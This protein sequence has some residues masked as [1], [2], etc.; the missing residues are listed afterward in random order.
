[1]SSPNP[2]FIENLRKMRTNETTARAGLKWLDEEDSKLIAKIKDGMQ[3]E[4][5]AKEFK[6]TVGSIKTRILLNAVKQ[7]DDDNQ[8]ADKVAADLKVTTEEIEEY[9]IKRKKF[10]EN[11][12][13][14]TNNILNK[15][16]S[17]PTIRDVFILVRELALMQKEMLNEIKNLK[18]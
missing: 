16:I 7:I 11:Q 2:A 5:I 18:K 13:N 10:E 15:N 1:M 17:N 12:N 9:R 6:R 4:D 3:V 14:L 8:P